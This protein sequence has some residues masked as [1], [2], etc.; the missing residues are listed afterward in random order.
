MKLVLSLNLSFAKNRDIPP[1][2]FSS[3][4]KIIIITSCGQG[5]GAP[6]VIILE[7]CHHSLSRYPS[8]TQ[9]ICI[10]LHCLHTHFWLK[11][12]GC[13]YRAAC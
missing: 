9:T 8:Q 2:S 6:A 1:G 10:H 11:S 4:L 7:K 12:V 5:Y 13:S 3:F